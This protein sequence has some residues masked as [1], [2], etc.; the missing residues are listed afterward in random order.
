MFRFNG[1]HM[2]TG[3]NSAAAVGL[4]TKWHLMSYFRER[5][6]FGSFQR[7]KMHLKLITF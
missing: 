7:K 1:N 6:C 2:K 3:P 4:S 5:I